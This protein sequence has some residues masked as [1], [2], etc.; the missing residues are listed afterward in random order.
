MLSV[1]QRLSFGADLSLVDV[2]FSFTVANGLVPLGKSSGC[3]L[4]GGNPLLS[5]VDFGWLF[6]TGCDCD[7]CL[8]ND[9]AVGGGGGGGGAWLGALLPDWLIRLLILLVLREDELLDMA[10][11]GGSSRA[12]T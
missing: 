6:L 9:S 3:G 11:F 2:G 10:G 1:G 5:E 4:G 12:S 8:L 7:D